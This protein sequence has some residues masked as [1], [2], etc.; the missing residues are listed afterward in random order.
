MY[1]LSFISSSL[2]VYF[3]TVVL[4]NSTAMGSIALVSYIPTVVVLTFVASITK[5][6]VSEKRRHT[7]TS[8]HFLVERFVSQVVC[9]LI[10]LLCSFLLDFS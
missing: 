1:L 5:N 6:L 4:N 2:T 7:D 8:S 10:M 9:S 3:C